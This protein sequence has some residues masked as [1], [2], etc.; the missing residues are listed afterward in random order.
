MVNRN[1]LFK[2][3]SIILIVIMS[4]P[5]NAFA[6][7][8]TG[9]TGSN[10]SGISKELG[11][12]S[13]LG[14][15]TVM[16]S[17]Y[18]SPQSSQQIS[19]IVS[20]L[21][22][23]TFSFHG[24][25][26]PIIL[27]NPVKNKDGEY[28][29][30]LY[31]PAKLLYN[32][33]QA[34]G[35]TYITNIYASA[36]PTF[37]PSTFSPF[38]N[39]TQI[40]VN[41]S[42]QPETNDVR[43]LIGASFVENSYGITGSGV[44][45]AIVDTGVDYAHPD[46][47]S[48]LIY[49]VGSYRT[50]YGTT[51][52]IREPMVLDA[53]ESQ[54]ILTQSFEANST[55]YINVSSASF[56]VL[57]PFKETVTPS[58]PYYYV[59]NISSSDGVYKFGMTLEYTVAGLVSVGVLM[60]DPDTP[61]NYTLLVIDANNDG[62][63]GDNGDI[64]VTYDGNRILYSPE[65]D[66]SLGV[67][68][69]FFYDVG[70]WFNSYGAYYPGWDLNGNY[71]SLFY[72]FEGHGTSCASAAAG[73]GI[74]NGIA[75]DANVIGVKA[76]WYGDVEMGLL[77]ASGF[78]V[79]NNGTIYY[80]GEK[81]ADVISD[82]WGISNFIYDI[83]GFGYDIESMLINALTTPGFLDPSFPGILVVQAAGNGGP[84]FGT[85]TSPGAA[86]GALT[87]SASTLWKVYQ[88]GYGYGGYTQDNIIMWSA[89]GPVPMGYL[90][91]D[92]VD[93]GAW[94]I[95]AAPIPIYYNIFGGTSY[96]T[97][98]TAGAVAL[99]I[100][101]LEEK[102]GSSANSV[103]PSMLKEILM[104]TADSL[105]YMPYDQGAGR[106][107]ITRA[108]QY[109][110]GKS[111]ELLIS[112]QSEYS[113]S[114][115]K[116]S[117]MW[118]WTFQD[119]MPGSFLGFYGAYLQVQN[120]NIPSA[121]SSQNYYGIYVPDVPL[122][123]MK[124][125]TFTIQNPSTSFAT[126]SI[127]GV[128]TM[129]RILA[130]VTYQLLF[131]VSRST[132]ISNQWIIL[133][134]NNIS[135][136]TSILLAEVNAPFRLL[137]NNDD[138]N[139]DFDIDVYAYVWINDTN[140]NGVPD[141]NELAFIN[142]GYATSNYNSIEIS[143]PRQLLQ[144]FGPNAKLAIRVFIHRDYSSAP[145]VNFPAT[146]T[147]SQFMLVKDP[148][149]YVPSISMNLLPGKSVTLQ[150]TVFAYSLAPT[151]YES[152]MRVRAT[153]SDGSYRVYDVPISYTVYTNMPMSGT[154]YLNPTTDTSLMLSPSNIRGD[155]DWDWRYEAG[156]WRYFYVNVQSPSLSAFEFKAT[157]T[158]SNTSLITYALGPDGQFAGGFFG[159]SVS[160][161]ENLWAG[162][163]LWTATGGIDGKNL[164]AITFPSTRY[165]YFEYPTQKS[166]TGIYTLIVRT[167]LFDGSTNAERFLVS[168]TPLQISGLPIS[169]LGP[170]G[171]VTYT[172]K[173]PYAATQYYAVVAPSIYPLFA[174]SSWNANVTPG[175]YSGL[176]PAGSTVTFTVKFNNYIYPYRADIPLIIQFNMPTSSGLPVYYKYMGQYK[177]YASTYTFEDWITSGSQWLFYS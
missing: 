47:Q 67:A 15:S 11:S 121:F 158:Y 132:T 100:Q 92:I 9:T 42:I 1:V 5:I 64:V 53:D 17:L 84:G 154:L 58:Y 115:S 103:P 160:Y 6:Y 71:I 107:N 134:P 131:N 41:N 12:L 74:V 109:V 133:S 4:A 62:V 35:L 76:L 69:G 165:R 114:A 118:Y 87:V 101:A 173:L 168:V 167:A 65:E 23:Y 145:L 83:S 123:G 137:D 128:Y 55:G 161:H 143:N 172:I 88:V 176:I 141:R 97:P 66:L 150:G 144:E 7:N 136:G 61:G 43:N 27:G 112:S 26:V 99:L 147:I 32:Q 46:L 117:S 48:K 59:G 57:D 72:D 122:N 93:V 10:L 153:F 25:Q 129:K 37:E 152:F 21:S 110:L 98:L 3:I 89:R 80:T 24:S 156:D 8:N 63:F 51:S 44:K 116:M 40:G 70:L 149:V 177:L 54:V 157:W 155:N 139:P 36:V 163:F 86:V 28:T 125:F 13:Q 102:V 82:S 159:E 16:V 31:G 162:T 85:V 166:N 73:N 170:Q 20:E 164:S 126:F 94:G 29:I 113:L 22:R 56:T 79:N 142:V 119:Y 95:T 78:D 14:N 104:N 50:V 174:Y 2:L 175:S 127:D 105:G 34:V 130:P 140:G 111:D 18:L 49:Y 45:I 52:N 135:S 124:S 169:K 33:I 151:A 68:G 30:R 39:Y 81:R 171:T 60:S 19:K 120:P 75:K 148:A 146:L 77:W 106:I 108:V 91:P 90:K 138:Y 38:D 96:A